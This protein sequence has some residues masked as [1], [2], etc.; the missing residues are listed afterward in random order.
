MD[1]TQNLTSVRLF[2]QGKK[3]Q[4]KKIN[5]YDDKKY[6]INNKK[7]D[8]PDLKTDFKIVARDSMIVVSRQFN[9]SKNVR[10]IY[11]V[12]EHLNLWRELGVTIRSVF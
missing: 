11:I 9:Y 8:L 10:M 5:K 6:L 4:K 2:N 3:G 7:Y 1:F 12:E